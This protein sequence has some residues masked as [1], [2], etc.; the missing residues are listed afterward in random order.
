[1]SDAGKGRGR[2]M[3]PHYTLL[4]LGCLLYTTSYGFPTIIQLLICP[5]LSLPNLLAGLHQACWSLRV[6]LI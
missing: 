6:N 5:I 2:I 1:M 4:I 3:G